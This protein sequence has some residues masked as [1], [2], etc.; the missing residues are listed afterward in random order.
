MLTGHTHPGL[1]PCMEKMLGLS[2]N[3]VQLNMCFTANIQSTYEQPPAAAA[4]AAAA[5]VQ[6]R[7]RF[8]SQL[9]RASLA[10][11]T[12]PQSQILTACMY[13]V[14]TPPCHTYHLMP[15]MFHSPG[16]WCPAASGMH[17]G[18]CMACSSRNTPQP[19]QHNG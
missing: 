5:A 13:Q 2:A 8:D 4:A 16:R 6:G 14:G 10:V 15:G 9:G 1:L 11:G 17:P 19:P 18:S 12:A 7:G 3:K